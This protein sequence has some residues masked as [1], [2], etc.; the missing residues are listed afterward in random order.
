MYDVNQAMWI[1]VGVVNLTHNGPPILT[2]YGLVDPATCVPA[3][4]HVKISLTLTNAG[5]YDI[6]TVS[7]VLT[8]SIL[9]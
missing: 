9:S 7:I 3:N 8:Y 5:V 4:R 6:G 2:T 1:T